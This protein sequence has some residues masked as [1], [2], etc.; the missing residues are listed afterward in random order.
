MW[1]FH[2]KDYWLL[3][4]KLKQRSDSKVIGLPKFTK[5]VIIITKNNV[6]FRTQNIIIFFLISNL[7]FI[8]QTFEKLIEQK[9]HNKFDLSR[10]D[11]SLLE[12]LLPFQ[13]EGIW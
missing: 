10:I 8:L 7:K 9:D 3:L 4:E 12:S 11:E 2:I 6:E 5:E 1:S 13:R